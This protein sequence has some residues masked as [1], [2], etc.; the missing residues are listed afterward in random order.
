MDIDYHTISAVALG[1]ALSAC[2]GFRVFI[3]LL[4]TS[5]TVY[6]H[7]FVLPGNMHWMGSGFSVACF[8]AASVI[9][10]G[11]YYFPF[12]VNILDTVAAPLAVAAGTMLAHALIPFPEGEPFLRWVMAF[13]AGGA[14]A[15]TIHIGTG[16]WRLF[17]TKATLGT[18]NPVLATGENAAAIAGAIA[19]FFIPLI[20]SI[21]MLLIVG[22]FAYQGN[23]TGYDAGEEQPAIKRVDN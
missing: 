7:W 19:S 18:G 21:V 4:I 16:I 17:S 22:W 11:A 6:N 14:T 15:G 1:I 20:M 13:V 8:A 10:V 5:I 9:E 2:C 23:H 12:L 3:P